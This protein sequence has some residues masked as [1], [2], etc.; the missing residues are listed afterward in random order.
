ML[1]PE[2]RVTLLGSTHC[3]KISPVEVTLNF[4]KFK[5]VPQSHSY[6]LV[7]FSFS[8]LVSQIAYQEL[9]AGQPILFKD[10]LVGSKYK[11]PPLVENLVAPN[12]H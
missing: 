9:S 6:W 3:V 11:V 12:V 4:R 10:G 5:P 2:I 7:A 8:F 1:H